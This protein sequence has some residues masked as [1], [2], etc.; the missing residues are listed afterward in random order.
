MENKV[1]NILFTLNASILRVLGDLFT[2]H[3]SP[4]LRSS[5]SLPSILILSIDLP[6]FFIVRSA[7]SLKIIE[8]LK[9][10]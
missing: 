4:G 1:E 10:E 5:K 2:M 8:R 3:S 7:F 6:V 9:K